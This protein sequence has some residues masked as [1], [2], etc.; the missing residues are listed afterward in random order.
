MKKILLLLVAVFMA[1]PF[2]YAEN[3]TDSAVTTN[4]AMPQNNGWEYI[5]DIWA[6]NGNYHE[7]VSLYVRVINQN[8]FYQIR[9]GSQ[10]YAVIKN[11]YYKKEGYKMKDYAYK[12]GNYYFN[13]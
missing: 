12:A 9:K 3:T 13:L 8:T 5:G 6:N 11:P 7:M 1:I 4:V 10:S 2:A